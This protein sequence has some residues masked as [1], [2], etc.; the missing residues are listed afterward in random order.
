[1]AGWK[2][3]YQWRF[4]ARKITDFHG[5]FSWRHVWWHLRVHSIVPSSAPPSLML[6]ISSHIFKILQVDPSDI[7]KSNPHR[8]CHPTAARLSRS[9]CGQLSQQRKNEVWVAPDNQF[10]QH[11]CA[12]Y[13]PQWGRLQRWAMA[14]S[15]FPDGKVGATESF[16]D[17]RRLKEFL[18]NIPMIFPGNGYIPSICPYGGSRKLSS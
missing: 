7:L 12:Q 10:T 15:I 13:L 11:P 5:P 8:K 9:S 14:V 1:M 6:V 4:I 17:R 3:P 2:F 18:V 16:P